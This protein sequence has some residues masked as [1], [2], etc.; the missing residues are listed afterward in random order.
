MNHK[1]AAVTY[2]ANGFNCSQAV[3]SVF[4]NE[5]GLTED[6]C[7]R[8][9]CAFG[10]G[11]ARNQH[12]CGAVTGALM[13]LG[14]QYGEKFSDN[15]LFKEKTYEKANE[16]IREFTERHGSVVCLELLDGLN[17]NDPEDRKRIDELGLFKTACAVYVK[18]AVEILENLK[19]F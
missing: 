6:Q 2:F 14:L 16:F 7:R 11:I 5:L 10:G 13:A 4:G 9:G 1:E 3:L 15:A 17:M 8:I 18:D 12:T 19:S